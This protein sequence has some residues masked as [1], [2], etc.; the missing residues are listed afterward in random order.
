MDIL[1]IDNVAVGE[2][3]GFFKKYQQNCFITFQPEVS[4]EYIQSKLGC[5]VN[6]R[7]SKFS[8]YVSSNE[9]PLVIEMNDNCVEMKATVAAIEERNGQLRL[10]LYKFRVMDYE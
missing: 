2:V 9:D 7:L 6:L 1:Y 4:I 5:N 10:N 8:Q 3:T